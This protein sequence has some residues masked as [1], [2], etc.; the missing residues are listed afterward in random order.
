MRKKAILSIS[1]GTNDPETSRKNIDVLESEY[2]NDHPD[3]SIYR[4]ITNE[5]VINIIRDEGEAVYAVRECLARLVLDGVTHVYAQPAYLLNGHEYEDLADMIYSHRAD[6]IEV[7]CGKPMITTHEDYVKIC[8]SIMAEE[9][10]DLGEDEA[11]VLIGHGTSHDSNS[12]YCT[13][14]YVFKDLG[15]DNV[16]VGT[17]NA[18]PQIEA[19][20][21][22]LKKDEKIKTVHIAPFMFVAG[23]AAMEGVCGDADDSMKTQLENAGYNVIAHRKCLGEY[24]GVRKVFRDHLD[25]CFD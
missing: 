19:V 15:F 2:K 18:F 25:S 21:R 4:V 20:I 5:A 11:V 23:K 3:C 14:D 6:F 12:V 10:A 24:A 16:F 17:F 1:F 22:H 9:F 13:L 8:K 7:K